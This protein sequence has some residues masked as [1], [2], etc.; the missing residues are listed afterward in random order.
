MPVL[1]FV[2]LL[3]GKANLKGCGTLTCSSDDDIAHAPTL[4]T[5]RLKAI[6]KVDLREDTIGF[7]IEGAVSMY[8]QARTHPSRALK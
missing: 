1:V 3:E 7:K 2:L 6:K 4:L 8:T 5:D